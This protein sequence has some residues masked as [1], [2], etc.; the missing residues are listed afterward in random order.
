LFVVAIAGVVK[1]MW[2]E[3]TLW[4]W[5]NQEKG[6]DI[7]KQRYARGE[8]SKDKFERIKKDME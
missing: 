8:I 4:A 5:K 1:W 2:R 3:K 6:S 7:L